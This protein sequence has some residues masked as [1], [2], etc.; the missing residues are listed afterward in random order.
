MFDVNQF[1]NAPH[2]DET[3]TVCR[4]TEKFK[5]KR[6]NGVE[7]LQFSDKNTAYDKT[8]YVLSHCL[9]SGEPARPIGE[10]NAVKFVERFSTLS[11]ALFSDVL[12]FTNKTLEKEAEIWA[13]SKKN[14]PTSPDSKTDAADTV[15]GTV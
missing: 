7:R 13:V 10:E 2:S 14:S 15:A 9:L 1:F 3:T 6:L 4:G 11:D 8:V 5:I 12:E